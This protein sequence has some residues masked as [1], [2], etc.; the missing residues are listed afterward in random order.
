MFLCSDLRYQKCAT[1]SIRRQE[2]KYILSDRIKVVNVV[3]SLLDTSMAQYPN[4]KTNAA[5]N[6]VREKMGKK[7]VKQCDP[8]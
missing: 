4:E 1:Y 5:S 7:S 2:M 3:Q 8:F 6:S